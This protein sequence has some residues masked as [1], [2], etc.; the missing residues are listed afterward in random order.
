[1]QGG[2]SCRELRSF[3]GL[4]QN[5]TEILR[6]VHRLN[7]RSSRSGVFLNSQENVVHVLRLSD[8]SSA[9]TGNSCT[10]AHKNLDIKFDSQIHC[11]ALLAECLAGGGD[12]AVELGFAAG[13]GDDRCMVDPS[14]KT[15]PV[16]D[17][18]VRTQPA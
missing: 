10:C 5:L 2:H 16:V 14:I 6:S 4:R 1:M 8:T 7:R 17:L 18:R 11:D 9:S 12:K 13:Q 15:A 3:H